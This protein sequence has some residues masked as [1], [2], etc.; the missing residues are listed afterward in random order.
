MAQRENA[1]R[2]IFLTTE[3]NQEAYQRLLPQIIRLRL[4]SGDPI[5]L[6][7]DSPGGNPEIAERIER[8]IRRPN[9]DGERCLLT[10][11]CIGRA[12]SVA[13]DMLA[14]GDYAIAYQ[15]AIIHCHGI[16]LTQP[17]LTVGDVPRVS[18]DIRADNERFA[19]RLA[20]AV[21]RRVV[22]LSSM[23]EA[24][25][26]QTLMKAVVSVPDAYHKSIREKLDKPNQDLIDA[27]FS[28]QAK[29]T[30]LI[31]HIT[32]KISTPSPEGVAF[33]AEILKHI[34][35]YEAK[36]HAA[37]TDFFSS[38]HLLTIQEDFLQIRDYFSGEYRALLEQEVLKHG[39][40][41]LEPTE[42]SK[43]DK[44]PDWP[45]KRKFLI[46]IVSPRLLP[47]WY[48]VVSLCRLLQE[49]EYYFWGREALWFGLVDEAIGTTLPSPRAYDKWKKEQALK[50]ASTTEQSP[51]SVQSPP[52]AVATGT[53]L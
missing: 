45:T 49:G 2:G 18:A 41:F 19:L 27:A 42:G 50:A 8:Q 28:R 21:F 38:S 30:A 43:Y 26:K 25:D 36:E 12:A 33:D 47:F 31:N 4:K 48:L 40:S 53:P 10:T 34:V 37:K 16:S 51:P 3:V 39:L 7:I 17:E 11:V 13:A 46:D 9:Q 32:T 1:E 35:D 5:C 44:I 24:D 6:F 52:S 20:T 22:F 14:S 29:I 23:T 15:G